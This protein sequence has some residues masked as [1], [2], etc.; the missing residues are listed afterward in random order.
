MF[1]PL[2]S[3]SNASD[4][5]SQVLFALYGRSNNPRRTLP[6]ETRQLTAVAST[7]MADENNTAPTFWRL[8]HNP[9]F[10][11]IGILA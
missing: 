9:F 11:K 7:V 3:H 4:F 1:F 6:I 8:F 5:P 2:N 10:R